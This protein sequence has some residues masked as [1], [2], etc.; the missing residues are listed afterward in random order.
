MKERLMRMPEVSA[1]T[2][3]SGATVYK[4][5]AIG[6]FPKPIKLT[7]HASGWVESEIEAWI[8]ARMQERDDSL[9]PK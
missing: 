3:L 2:G 8:A 5:I 7:H 9:N 4:Q 1:R 6:R